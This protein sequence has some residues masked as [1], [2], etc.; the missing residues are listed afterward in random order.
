MA[1]LAF[2]YRVDAVIALLKLMPDFDL[3]P[4][5]LEGAIVVLIALGWGAYLVKTF[6]EGF[7]LAGNCR[8]LKIQ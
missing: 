6:I 2:L 4:L 8:F 7:S 3:K 1:Y 5:W